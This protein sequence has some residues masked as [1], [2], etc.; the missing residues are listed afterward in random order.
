MKEWDRKNYERPEKAAAIAEA[1]KRRKQ[2]IR[3]LVWSIKHNPCTD[4]GLID[5]VVMDFDHLGD[6]E[7]NISIAATRGMSDKRILSEI[8]K[9]ELVCANCHRRRTHSRGGWKRNVV[10]QA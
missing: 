8:E 4:C 2:E 3:D 10:V 1:R 6:K 5:P 7:F 9:C